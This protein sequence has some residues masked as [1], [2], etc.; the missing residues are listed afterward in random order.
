VLFFIRRSGSE[1]P[2]PWLLAKVRVFAIGAALALGGMILDQGWMIWA[3]I[4]VLLVG[5][6]LR[7]LPR[8]DGSRASDA[9]GR[10]EGVDADEPT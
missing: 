7:F 5:I 2:D 4:G 8:T 10:T 9:P 3:A 1:G 6:V